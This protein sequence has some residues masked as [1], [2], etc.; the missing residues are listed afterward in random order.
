[1]TKTH[2]H[3]LSYEN[4]CRNIQNRNISCPPGLLTRPTSGRIREALFNII[5]FEVEG[6][7]FLDLF[8]GSGAMGIEAIS[9]GAASAT[10]VEISRSCCKYIEKNIETLGIKSQ[11]HVICDDAFEA[12]KRFE[13]DKQ[14][15]D[16][17][18]IDPPYALQIQEGNELLNYSDLIL[19]MVDRGNLLNAK[20]YLFI[21]DSKETVLNFEGLKSLEFIK[22]RACGR[23]T[24]HQLRAL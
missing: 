21:E 8:A 10:L 13:R 18:Y 9:R 5:Q 2:Q 22:T 24:L 14:S 4:L 17:I 12:L 15:F 3:T 19:K 1:L 11:C 20:G 6:I 23:S 16:V 7:K